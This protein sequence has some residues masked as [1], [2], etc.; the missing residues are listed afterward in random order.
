MAIAAPSALGGVVRN[1]PAPRRGMIGERWYVPYLFILPH[2]VFFSLFIGWPFL[3][4]IWIS[5]HDFDFLREEQP[6][7]GLHNFLI[8][9]TPG[10]IHFSRFWGSLWNTVIFVIISTPTM[11]MV[12][13]LLAVLLNGRYPGRNFFRSVYFAPWTLSVAVVGVTWRWL[14]NAQLSPLNGPLAAIGIQ[15]PG[16]L[17]SNPSAWIS[18]L[19]A[20]LWWTIGFNTIILL[21]GI[22]NIPTELYEA[23]AV[24]G[25]SR[26]KQFWRITIPSLRPVLL[27]VVNLQ[28]IA[29]FNLF[30]QPQLMTG[31]GPPPNETTPV[32]FYIYNTG[33]TGSYELG[34]ASAMALLVATAMLVVSVVNFRVFRTEAV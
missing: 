2:F 28:I 32:M 31:G 18:I 14:L 8:L 12:G 19:V 17:T 29:S 34:V 22:Q 26:W 7:V 20:T 4:G 1:A 30:G 21:A 24:D 9:F 6:F 27:L 10:S 3:L 23:S 11:V 25:A 15:A 13:L 33:F 16:W 5:L